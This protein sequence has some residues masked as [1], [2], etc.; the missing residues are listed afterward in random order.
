MPD[1]LIAAVVI[2]F[3]YSIVLLLRSGSLPFLIKKLYLLTAAGKK[4]QL[5]RIQ[6][7]L[8]LHSGYFK[9]LSENGRKI[10]INRCLQF[11]GSKNFIG[12]EGMKVTFE[13]EIKLAAAAIQITFGFKNFSFSHYH[14]VK[15]FPEPFYS[16]LHDRYLKGG[17]S[18]SGV[19]FFSWKDFLEGYNSPDDRYNLGLHEMAHALRLQLLHGSDFDSRF[20]NYADQWEEIARPEFGS[21]EPT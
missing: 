17:A 4:Q 14:T 10:F 9:A 1:N 21:H 11:V 8:E 18:T 5:L 6:P 7:F 13:M 3:T 19:L 16:R 15:I 20:A 12:M 2:L